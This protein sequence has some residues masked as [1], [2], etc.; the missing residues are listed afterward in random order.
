MSKEIEKQDQLPNKKK[1]FFSIDTRFE[2]L[3]TV[4]AIGIA[5]AIVLVIVAFV[6][7]NP[8][9]AITALL[10]GPV[11]SLRRFGNVIE[12]MIPLTFTGLAVSVILKTNRFNLSSEGAFFLGG[13]VATWIAIMS[14]FSPM[15]TIILIVVATLLVGA[16]VGFIPAI[17]NKKFYANELVT[18]LM[19]NYIVAYFVKYLLNNKLRDT[20]K[21]I[22]QSLPIPKDVRLS[23]LIPGTR[24]H[25]GLLVMILLVVAA[26]LIIYKT[27]WGYALRATGANEKFAVYTGIKVS[28][29][30]LLAQMI[31]TAIAGL[32]GGIEIL[33]MYSSF[34]WLE[35]PGYGFDGVIISTLARGNPAMVPLSAFF[36][37]YVRVGADILNRTSDIPAEIVSIVQATIILL[38]AA[39]AFLAK[40][41]HKMV[42]KQA[43]VLTS[44]GEAK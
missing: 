42:V 34:Q 41:K 44:A 3:R 20:S 28:T 39:K 5:L 11:S 8:I 37:A 40:R 35:T 13:I 24:I 18:S 31:G 9:E 38:I 6:S 10:L 26:W 4:S 33:G 30:V 32:G 25:V 16:L 2:I 43:G 14:P 19:L 22:I 15:I 27:K 21:S 17:L 12:L 7:S 1:D 36:L 23:L 29:V